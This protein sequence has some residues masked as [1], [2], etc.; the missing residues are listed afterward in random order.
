MQDKCM[1]CVERAIVS[2]IILDTTDE[3]LGDMGQME[4]HFGLF[5]Y[6]VNLGTR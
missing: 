4:A 2:E 5:E 1:V 6:C 3:L